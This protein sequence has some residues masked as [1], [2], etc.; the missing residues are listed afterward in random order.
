[1]SENFEF[2]KE[3]DQQLYNKLICGEKD[4]KINF[5]NSVRNLRE[6]FESFINSICIKFPEIENELNQQATTVSLADRIRFLTDTCALSSINSRFRGLSVRN[7]TDQELYY[8]QGGDS[9]LFESRI[10]RREARRRI[11]HDTDFIRIVCNDYSH[12][13]PS[14]HVFIRT[15]E[16][17]LDAY[18]YFHRILRR[19]Y[20]TSNGINDFSEDL[21]PLGKYNVEMSVTPANTAATKCEREYLTTYQRSVNLGELGIGWAIICEYR[22][23]NVDT[24][25]ISR[26]NDAQTLAANRVPGINRPVP[27]ADLNN[28]NTPFYIIAYEFPRKPHPIADVFDRLTPKDKY[29]I[30]VQVARYFKQLHDAK[31]YHRM[32][33]YECIYLY[34]GEEGRWNPVVTKFNF[35]KIDIDLRTVY[36]NATR[37]V[38][39]LHAGESKYIAPEWAADPNRK[40]WEKVDIYS[41][42]VFLADL[43]SGRILDS[44]DSFFETPNADNSVIYEMIDMMTSADSQDRPTAHD[45]YEILEG[46]RG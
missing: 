32:L 39:L 14:E 46:Y 19:Y 2:V 21:I 18:R 6:A 31:I 7:I 35:S 38:D 41:L 12:S 15:Y 17:A 26:D 8:H 16:T 25:F 40:N 24:N 37:A 5:I 20:C 29:D 36:D 3:R 4:L 44:L 45:V 27:V 10:K 22:K 9:R 42:G 28:N 11:R 30:A 33:N 34:Q 13:N 1:M 43:Y 23:E